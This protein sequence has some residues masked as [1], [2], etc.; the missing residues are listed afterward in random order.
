MNHN[1]PGPGGTVHWR[2]PMARGGEWMIAKT[3]HMMVAAKSEYID[4]AYRVKDIVSIVP[5]FSDA[6]YVTLL[7]DMRNLLI[8]FNLLKED[9]EDMFPLMDEIYENLL[10]S[11]DKAIEKLEAATATQ[12]RRIQPLRKGKASRDCDS[13]SEPPTKKLKF[14]RPPHV[15]QKPPPSKG[16]KNCRGGIRRS[17][18]I[19]QRDARGRTVAGKNKI[20]A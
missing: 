4:R 3:P 12:I 15:K 1:G 5:Y 19:Q 13:T 16:L 14:D 7:D 11:F 8:T 6:L 2:K 17:A 18:R 20:K 9:G 10:A